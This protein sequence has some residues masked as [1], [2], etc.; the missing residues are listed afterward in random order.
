MISV[1]IIVLVI[2]GKCKCCLISIEY[3][4]ASVHDL[5]TPFSSICNWGGRRLT[6]VTSFALESCRLGI[7]F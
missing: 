6:L 5:H 3:T 2:L 1:Q 7:M 4:A